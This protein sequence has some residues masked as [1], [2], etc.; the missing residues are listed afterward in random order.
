MCLCVRVSAHLCVVRVY[1]C[2]RACVR[3]CVL[4]T[5]P[6]QILPVRRSAPGAIVEFLQGFCFYSQIEVH[7]TVYLFGL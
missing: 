5:V 2:E 4:M 6:V 1:V 7:Y 3:V